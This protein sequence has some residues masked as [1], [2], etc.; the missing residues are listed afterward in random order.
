MHQQQFAVSEAGIAPIM[1]L[2]PTTPHLAQSH[3]FEVVRPERR[4]ESTK[5]PVVGTQVAGVYVPRVARPEV[6][7]QVACRVLVAGR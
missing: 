4:G 2:I 1:P 6:V 3:G 7:R 5:E